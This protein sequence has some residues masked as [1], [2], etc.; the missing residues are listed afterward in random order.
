[1]VSCIGLRCHI[2]R[3]LLKR[4]M[5]VP[6][7]AGNTER[8][9]HSNSL[10]LTNPTTLGFCLWTSPN[11]ANKVGFLRRTTRLRGGAVL[12]CCHSSYRHLQCHTVTRPLAAKPNQCRHLLSSQVGLP[13]IIF[14]VMILVLGFQNGPY[15]QRHKSRSSLL[16][17]ANIKYSKVFTS[18]FNIM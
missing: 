2:P 11:R 9:A 14:I 4:G 5:S 7:T 16:C 18:N 12:I 6:L 1:M 8:S 15:P 17:N 3:V 10:Y 13:E